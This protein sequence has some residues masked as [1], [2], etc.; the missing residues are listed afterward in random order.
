MHGGGNASCSL[1]T[2]SKQKENMTNKPDMA[3]INAVQQVLRTLTLTMAT[4][5]RVDLAVL[6]QLL[7]SSTQNPELVPE[8]RA[9]LNDLAAGT[10]KIAGAFENNG[11]PAPEA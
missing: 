7:A 9:M 4:A 3:T 6:S 2:H 1:L 10:A 5:A 11:R 8:A